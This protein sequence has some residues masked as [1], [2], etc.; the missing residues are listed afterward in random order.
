MLR[1]KYIVTLITLLLIVVSCTERIDIKL[2]SSAVRLVVDGSVTTDS[3]RQKVILTETTSYFYNQ[4]A[5]AVTRARVSISDGTSV[6]SLH[7]DS[8]GV[9]RT[10]AA[11][12]GVPGRKYILNISLDSPLGGYSDY[13]AE[14]TLFPV[15][16]L[17]SIDLKYHNDWGD[18]GIWEVRCYVQDPP[19][20]DYYRFLVSDNNRMITDTLTEWFVTDDRFFNGNYAYGATV[21]YLRQDKNN[22]A[23]IAGDTVMVEVNSIGR[24]YAYF[25][26]NAQ[27]ENAGSNPLFS[28]PPANVKG[29]ISN[30][31]IGFF[32]AFS[33]TRASTTVPDH[34]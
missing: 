13:M 5:P 11:L 29:N 30:G 20:A 33:I 17:D 2:D 23:L 34:F 27:A 26:W 7:E 24:D 18:N 16:K 9:Y 8:A 6:F 25:I 1:K 22:E 12:A 31:A 14:S 15:N 19:T 10:E 28:G 3:I 32:S 4:P 21:A